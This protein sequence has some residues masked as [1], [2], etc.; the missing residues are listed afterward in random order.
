MRRR[1]RR[2]GRPWAVPTRS[3]SPRRRCASSRPR[4]PAVRGA[5][6]VRWCCCSASTSPSRTPPWTRTWPSRS[7][8]MRSRR[9]SLR[10][11]LALPP[12]P[13]RSRPS[14]PRSPKPRRARAGR[15]RWSSVRRRAGIGRRIRP[16]TTSWLSRP[17]TPP[18]PKRGCTWPSTRP[19]AGSSPPLRRGPLRR[20]VRLRARCRTPPSRSSPRSSSMASAAAARAT[21]TTT[22]L[23]CCA[24]AW[25]CVPSG[26][27]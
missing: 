22:T 17:S 9:R 23:S 21:P 12:I 13:S 25:P 11:T 14:R 27:G 1:H 26:D 20:A 19:R 16:R 24:A 4:G 7:S 5:T 10:A 3:P 2:V 18:R 8:P 15:R 6:T